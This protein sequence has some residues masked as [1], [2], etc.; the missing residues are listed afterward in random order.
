MWFYFQ[1]LPVR[2]LEVGCGVGNTTFPLIQWDQHKKMFLYTSDYSSVAV[3]VLKNDEKYDPSRM[4][5][6]QWD[7]TQPPPPV[8]PPVGSL[9]IVICI[10]VLSALHPSQAKQAVQHLVELLKP[11]GMFLLKDYGRYD[12][13]QLRFK[14]GRFIEEN[15]Y[16][17]G[18]GTL[19]YFFSQDELDALL[20]EIGLE[21]VIN[22]VDKRLIVNRAKQIKMFRQWLQVKYKKPS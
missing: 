6:F 12:L 19:V 18:D 21:K 15:L 10:Y 5:A 3:D 2:V 16:C 7:I 9:D 11:G 20:T 17:R 8:A 4:I 14:K 22:V 1:E 13:T